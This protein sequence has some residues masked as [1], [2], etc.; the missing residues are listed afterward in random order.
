MRSD[1]VAHLSTM[2]LKGEEAKKKKKKSAPSQVTAVNINAGCDG[3]DSTNGPLTVPCRG[4]LD[5]SPQLLIT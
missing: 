2:V 5:V 3:T 4:V 1:I